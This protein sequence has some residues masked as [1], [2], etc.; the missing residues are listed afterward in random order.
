MQCHFSVMVCGRYPLI[1]WHETYYL[2]S[3]LCFRD[4]FISTCACFLSKGKHLMVETFLHMFIYNV[5]KFVVS[6]VIKNCFVS[7]VTHVFK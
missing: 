7:M 4:G 2:Y 6:I 5:I 3:V 1:C